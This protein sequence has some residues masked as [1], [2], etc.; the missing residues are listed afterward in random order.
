MLDEKCAAGEGE[1]NDRLLGKV[2][3]NHVNELG[4]SRLGWTAFDRIRRALVGIRS[5]EDTDVAQE[6]DPFPCRE[7]TC[8]SGEKR[9]TGMTGRRIPQL[10]LLAT[11]SF[12]KNCDVHNIG[13]RK[14]WIE[15]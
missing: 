14:G 11:S 3:Q 13:A 12:V 6:C 15:L 9:R 5:L 1:G 7:D 8:L 2:L 4:G 10:C